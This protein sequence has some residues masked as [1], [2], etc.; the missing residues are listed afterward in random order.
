M[1][2]SSPCTVKSGKYFF[3][4]VFFAPPSHRY[5]QKNTFDRILAHFL[6]DTTLYRLVASGSGTCTITD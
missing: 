2:N 5:A 6:C 3:S 4:A 1:Y